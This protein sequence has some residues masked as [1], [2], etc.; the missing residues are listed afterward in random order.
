LLASPT[1]RQV[2]TIEIE[3]AMV[4]AA[5]EFWP[6]NM[7]AY[8]DRR[9]RIH[10][11]DAKTFFAGSSRRYD[12]LVS[13]PSNPWVS[14]VAGL[15]S[16]DYYRLAARSLEDDGVFVQWLQL[17]EFN[18]QLVASVLKALSAN[19]GDYVIY[20]A[21]MGDILIVATKGNRVPDPNP[22]AFRNADLAAAL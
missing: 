15:F 18:V 9:S 19:F 13:E 14:G 20:A 2:D 6:R 8:D 16:H 7:R 12:I 1:L 21:N 22:E 10:I 4:Q 11:E 3:E 17:Y 5:R